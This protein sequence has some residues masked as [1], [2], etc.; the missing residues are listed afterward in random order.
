M[1]ANMGNLSSVVDAVVIL[2][3]QKNNRTFNERGGRREGGKERKTNS[4]TA[5]SASS[6][7]LFPPPR[8][9]SPILR[10]FRVFSERKEKLFAKEGAIYRRWSSSKSKWPAKNERDTNLIMFCEAE[11][12]GGRSV[13]PSRR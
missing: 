4:E 5:G 1:V 12:K 11:Q 8:N 13:D 3:R 10:S 9:E 6:S 2:M 7:S